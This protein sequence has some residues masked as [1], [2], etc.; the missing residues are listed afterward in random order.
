MPEGGLETPDNDDNQQPSTKLRPKT[1]HRHVKR[2]RSRLC[3]NDSHLALHDDQQTYFTGLIQF[4]ND[5]GAGK[6]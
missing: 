3:P 5:V 6:S 4:I 2:G 1:G